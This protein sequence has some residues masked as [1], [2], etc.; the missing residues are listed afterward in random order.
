MRRRRRRASIVGGVRRPWLSLLQAM[1]S[2]QATVEL[3]RLW[4]LPWRNVLV[5]NC[6]MIA[7]LKFVLKHVGVHDIDRRLCWGSPTA[8]IVEEQ[9]P[10][11]HTG[12]NIRATG[13]SGCRGVIPVPEGQS[14]VQHRASPGQSWTVLGHIRPKLDTFG[15][16]S[17]E[18][19]QTSV[20]V[21]RIRPG[22]GEI[23]RDSRS[24]FGQSRGDISTAQGR[25]VCSM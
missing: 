2:P 7:V 25:E 5:R 10:Q 6:E 20:V 8:P 9:F 16:M 1:E 22:F 14:V 21:S 19:G 15:P 18:I 4:C 23:W 13:A 17:T 3:R 24:V 11:G 12:S